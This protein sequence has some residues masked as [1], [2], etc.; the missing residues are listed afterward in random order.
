MMKATVNASKASK[1]V[2]AP[3]NTAMRR[4]HWEDGRDSIRAAMDSGVIVALF[5]STFRS[6]E[7]PGKL[8]TCVK[9]GTESYLGR[10]WRA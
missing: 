10:G 8:V 9:C 1:K 3:S 7:T 6:L 5:A 2:A 4:F